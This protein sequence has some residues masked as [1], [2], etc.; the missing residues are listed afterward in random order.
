M[1]PFLSFFIGSYHYKRQQQNHLSHLHVALRYSCIVRRRSGR[2]LRESM[3]RMLARLVC[4]WKVTGS[5]L[6]C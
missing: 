5:I 4:V 2:E 6:G 1:N 3:V